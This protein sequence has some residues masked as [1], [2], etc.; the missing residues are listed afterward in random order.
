MSGNP[1]P[2]PGVEDRRANE[3]LDSW[4]EIAVYLKREVRTV[5][6]WEKNEGLPVR[7][8]MHDK[9]GTVFA[10]KSEINTW[11]HERQ[12]N[13]DQ[14]EENGES[15]LEAAVD[16]LAAQPSRP[17]TVTRR[18]PIARWI[19]VVW[20]SVLVLTAVGLISLWPRIQE[21][22]WPH[23][24]ILGV[25]PFKSPGAD[26]EAHHIADGL[27]EEMVSRLGK[28]HPARLGIKEL[29]PTPGLSPE[30]IGKQAEADYVLQGS[31]RS[32]GQRVA[33][34]AQLILVKDQTS[35]WGN[36]YEPDLRDVIDT[37][38]KVAGNIVGEVLNVLPHDTR[39][40]PQPTRDTYEAYL[41]GR[42]LW[43]KRTP[44]NLAKAITYFEKAIEYDPTYAPSYAGLADCYS[45]L[46]SAPYTILPPKEAF[47]KAEAAA[48][49]AL[50]LDETLADAHVSLG[51]SELVYDR[52]LQE[53]RKEFD[54]ALQLRPGN[55]TAHQFY[56]YYLTSQ[57]LLDEAIAER[58]KAQELDPAS[59]LLNSA[60]GEAYYHARQYDVTIEQNRKA[61]ELDPSYAVALVNLGLAFGQKGMHREAR[62]TFQKLLGMAPDEPAIL[63]LLGHEYAV[64]GDARHAREMLA[65]LQQI[66][67]T[68]YVPSLYIAMIY[69]GLGDK[70]QAF[71]WLDKAY[72]ERCEY[73]VY[74]PSEPLA[75]PL[76]GDAR[77]TQLLRR[78]GLRS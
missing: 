17:A 15:A 46:G 55:A 58:K 44:E 61:L 20:L 23:K 77:F 72:D 47:P 51:Y 54:R 39:P 43:N 41:T 21:R 40:A 3:R 75:D 52:N 8:L 73:L 68:R 78:L 76:R 25:L 60:L 71:Q 5:Q 31:V 38:I 35:I 74:L 27:T 64:S 22:F 24:V 11:W 63:A 12:A 57:N 50:A 37:E 4:K 30:Q 66:S 6:R 56:G 67:R 65:R 32:D 19:P 53:A 69:T 2:R 70:D 29:S 33:I 45:L 16:T 34:T 14:D 18:K 7:R 48:R 42:Y 13:I 10:Y 36:S 62:A 49:K 28:L 59:P 26:P 9:Q 1:Q